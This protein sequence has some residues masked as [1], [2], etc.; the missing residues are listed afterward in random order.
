MKIKKMVILN[1][2]H[3]RPY[4]NGSR[5]P[6]PAEEPR[7]ANAAGGVP[8][9]LQQLPRA[10]AKPRCWLHNFREGGCP[11]AERCFFPHLPFDEDFLQAARA[12]SATE[13]QAT[14]I[15]QV[16]L[17]ETNSTAMVFQ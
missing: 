4:I 8:G 12:A 17:R 9:A 5:A 3:T 10:H 15:E 11:F 2:C 14:L 7:G 16:A 13:T 1:F 6:Q